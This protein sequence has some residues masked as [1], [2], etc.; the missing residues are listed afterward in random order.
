M[1]V[2][3]E[4]SVK[5]YAGLSDPCDD[6]IVLQLDTFGKPGPPELRS[7]LAIDY[8]N[9]N[10]EWSGGDIIK[11]DHNLVDTSF[12]DGSGF[13]VGGGESNLEA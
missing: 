7:A 12:D 13:I 2:K 3:R 9:F 11:D 1:Y 10:T 4:A 6:T 8:D 5:S